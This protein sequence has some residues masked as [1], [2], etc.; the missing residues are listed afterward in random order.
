MTEK[1]KLI[2]KLIIVCGRIDERDIKPSDPEPDHCY[3]YVQAQAIRM[4]TMKQLNKL[5]KE[6][7]KKLWST[8]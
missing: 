5:L 2:Q 6:Y 8:T 4:L 3:D 1:Q 7:Q